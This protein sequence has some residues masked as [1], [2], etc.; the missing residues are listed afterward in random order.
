MKP[1]LIN[2][3]LIVSDRLFRSLVQGL[4]SRNDVQFVEAAGHGVAQLILDFPLMWAFG[5]LDRMDSVERGRTI[6]VTQSSHAAYLDAI[7]SYHV[8]GV[9]DNAEE[10]RLLSCVYAAS[11]SL[12]TY[13]WRSG[14]TYMELRITRLLLRGL[15]TAAI[16]DAL[17][18][19]PKTVNAH[20]S[21]ILNKLGHESRTQYLAA[22]VG[23]H[24]A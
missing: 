10:D 17:R 15:D 13:R 18:V 3:R 23:Q 12:R 14:L 5:Q 19:S 24:H 7:G 16:A 21:N 9:I 8:S 22:L 11:A 20:I 2:L 4:A 1:G 6:V